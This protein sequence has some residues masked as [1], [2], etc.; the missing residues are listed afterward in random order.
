MKGLFQFRNDISYNL[1][2]RSQIHIHPVGT[3]FG[4]RE[5]IQ[6][7]RPKIWKLIPD[8]MK[9]LESLWEFK[10]AIKLW[11]PTSCPCRLCKQCFYGTDFLNRVFYFINNNCLQY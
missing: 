7:L 10:R 4:G 3:A 11:K 8:E 9:A 6:Y 5:S 2:Q 1:R